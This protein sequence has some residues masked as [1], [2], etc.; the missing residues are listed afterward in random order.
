MHHGDETGHVFREDPARDT[1]PPPNADDGL[2][3]DQNMPVTDGELSDPDPDA[4]LADTE[5]G[6]YAERTDAMSH[7]VETQDQNTDGLEENLNPDG[8][9]SEP[10]LTYGVVGAAG[11]FAPLPGESIQPGPNE[12][13]P[14]PEGAPVDPDLAPAEPGRSDEPDSLGDQDGDEQQ[15]VPNPAL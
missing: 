6:R 2:F 12:P 10:D 5:T 14:G 8:R 3:N 13:V 9:L 4:G 15:T 1:A 11:G 7:D